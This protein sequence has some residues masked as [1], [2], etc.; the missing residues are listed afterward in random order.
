MTTALR[1]IILL[2]LATLLLT[3]IYG[4]ATKPVRQDTVMQQQPAPNSQSFWDSLPK[5]KGWINDYEGL[6]SDNEELVLD[7][8]VHLLKNETGIEIAVVTIDAVSI[9]KEKFVEL[10]QRM[11]N[12]WGVGEAGK[13][14][15]ILV[16][17]SRGHRMIRIN[18]GSGI[19]KLITDEETKE[20]IDSYFIPYF[21]AGGF[22]K[23]TI[24]GLTEL[25]HR[26]QAKR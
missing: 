2:A 26:L 5:P 3:N 13:D 18:N 12:Q 11:A 23:G 15:G 17:I 22:Y 19:E 10:T 4:Q 24:V 1:H 7:S 21:K 25:I 8:L 16:G 14:N 20:I 6:Y 9:P